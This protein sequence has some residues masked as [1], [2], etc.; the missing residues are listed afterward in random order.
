MQSWLANI[1]IFLVVLVVAGGILVA[2]R[3]GYN[4]GSNYTVVRCAQGHLFT[5]IWIPGVSLKSL[6]FGWF[7]LQH[8]PVGDHIT[9]VVAVRDSDL[10]DEERWI[11]EQHHDAWIP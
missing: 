6:R 5:T 11:A 9:F 10:T 4:V 3:Y 1:P 2:R 8:C 7:R